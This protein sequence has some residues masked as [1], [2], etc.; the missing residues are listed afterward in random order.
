MMKL[1]DHF[2]IDINPEH[3]QDEVPWGCGELQEF[4]PSML[5]LEDLAGRQVLEVCTHCGTYGM[6]GAGMLALRLDGDRKTSHPNQDKDGEWLV[7]AIWGADDHLKLNH[8]SGPSG[9]LSNILKFEEYILGKGI[10]NLVLE[11]H[12]I[13]ITFGDVSIEASTDEG[14]DLSK[15][16]FL[17]PTVYLWI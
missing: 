4:S 7:F 16:L 17:S 14:V 1:L 5:S 2:E 9:T 12:H 13:S 6:G 15:A 10:T 11:H 3:A 8:T